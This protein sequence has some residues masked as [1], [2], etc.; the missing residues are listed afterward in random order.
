[1]RNILRMRM[2]IANKMKT[3]LEIGADI[4]SFARSIR[5]KET[6]AALIRAVRA[7]GYFNKDPRLLKTGEQ[8]SSGFSLATPDLT[9]S[10]EL[11]QHL[12]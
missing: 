10:L 6:A 3:F 1:M 9:A 11:R 5:C 8:L 2:P 4:F 12:R 7:C